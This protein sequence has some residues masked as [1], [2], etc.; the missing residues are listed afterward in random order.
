MKKRQIIS[1][2]LKW[3]P[4]KLPDAPCILSSSFL[5]PSPRAVLH[6]KGCCG[7]VAPTARRFSKGSNHSPLPVCYLAKKQAEGKHYNVALSHAAK[8]LV[9]LILF[10]SGENNPEWRLSPDAHNLRYRKSRMGLC[11]FFGREHSR[12]YC[13]C[14]C[15]QGAKALSEG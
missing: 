5:S 7:F 11:G 1:L 15:K 2:E 6:C 13:P 10:G 8:K 12:W 9:R 3:H 4:A 14:L